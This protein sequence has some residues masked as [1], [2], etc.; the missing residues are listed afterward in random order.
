MYM[1][2]VYVYVYVY[3]F[4]HPI[5]RKYTHVTEFH[6]I[7]RSYRGGSAS[8]EMFSRQ[9]RLNRLITVTFLQLDKA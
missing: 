3:S 9:V 1:Y 2:Y 6:S 4:Q 5:N 7:K 8:E